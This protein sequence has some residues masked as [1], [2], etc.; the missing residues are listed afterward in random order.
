MH[1]LNSVGPI[2]FYDC[3][4]LVVVQWQQQRWYMIINSLISLK[5]R[6]FNSISRV[7]QW[8]ITVVTMFSFARRFLSDLGLSKLFIYNLPIQWTRCCTGQVSRQETVEEN[9]S[10]TERVFQDLQ[11]QV[12][13]A[14]ERI[15]K[16]RIILLHQ[17]SMV[18]IRFHFF[19]FHCYSSPLRRKMNLN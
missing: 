11:Y 15:M 9:T 17:L 3:R 16:M 18:C 19:I 6:L 13:V 5:I 10:T 1:L 4:H 7:A 12:D 2:F 14:I 8:C